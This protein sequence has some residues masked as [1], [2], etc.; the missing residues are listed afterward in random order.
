MNQEMM[1]LLYWLAKIEEN[2]KKMAAGSRAA[3][4][5]RMAELLVAAASAYWS[6]SQHIQRRMGYV[7]T[8][9]LKR[10]VYGLDE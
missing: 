7:L 3:E 8:D 4:D 5:K 10:K 6:V 9:A 1:D 2:H